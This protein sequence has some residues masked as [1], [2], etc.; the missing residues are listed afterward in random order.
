MVPKKKKRKKRTNFEK[1]GTVWDAS[2]YDQNSLVLIK[3]NVDKS[4]TE[5]DSCR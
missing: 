1:T 2:R 3:T 5:W 4:G